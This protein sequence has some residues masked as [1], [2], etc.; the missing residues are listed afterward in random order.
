MHR[1]VSI[2]MFAIALTSVSALLAQP[3]PSKPIRIIVPFPPGDTLDTM[4]RLIAPKLTERLGQ[5]IVIDNRPG[6]AG[7]LGLELAARARP[8]GYT[9]V[10][11]SGGNLVVQPHTYKNLPYQPLKDF[12]PI[13]LATTNILALVVNV[14]TPFKSV[15]D[16]ITY[17]KAKPGQL[18]FATNGEGGFPHMTTELFRVMGN[19]TYLHVPYKGSAQIFTELIGGRVDTTI[20]GIGSVTSYVRTGRVRLLAVTSATRSEVFPDV[21]TIAETLPGY[22]S[23]GWIGYLAP[24]GTSTK[25]LRSL[26]HEIASAI[27]MPD[28]KDKLVALGLD[29]VAQPPDMFGQM[30]RRDYEKYAQLIRAIGFQPQ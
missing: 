10:G 9:L 6:A 16:L 22:E 11:G 3:Y 17:A 21:P 12:L 1:L 24:A 8:D 2:A 19:F 5:N 18:R 14:S 4:S 27:T 25:I 13:T 29:V 26:N 7:Q 20:L 15:G 28:V 23:R 30:L